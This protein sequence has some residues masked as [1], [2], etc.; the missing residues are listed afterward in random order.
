[1]NI[2][3][4]KGVLELCVLSLLKKNDCYGYEISEYLSNHIDIAD[5]FSEEEI[6][7]RLGA[8][9]VLAAQF[10][11][12]NDMENSHGKKAVI[13]VG[14]VFADIFSGMFFILLF[15][16]EVIM[17]AFSLASAVAAICLFGH[18]SIF[19]LIPPLPY[20][21][22]VIFAPSLAAL[23]VLGSIG[24][25]YFAA[26]IRQLIC[27]YSRFHHNATAFASGNAVL[28]SLSIR[29]QPHAKTN[30]RIWTVALFSLSI[31]AAC[32]VLVIAVSIVFSGAIEFWHAWGWFGYC[33]PL[34]T[35]GA[36]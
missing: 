30:R 34:Y 22:G 35:G 13:I 11:R 5:G 23:A 7:V 17:A 21:C 20:P 16:W 29:P 19:S 25:V 6:S 4:R 10:E 12:R 26:F 8:P 33:R 36:L 2:Q 32:F 28:P 14:L 27:S 24:C 9:A 1:M 15:T 31:F 18:F 3:Y